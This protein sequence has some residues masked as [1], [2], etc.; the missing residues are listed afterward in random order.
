M[1]C[2]YYKRSNIT[3]IFCMRDLAG[4][5]IP[6]IRFLSYSDLPSIYSS[7]AREMQ[8]GYHLKIRIFIG[9][10]TELIN[11]PGSNSHDLVSLTILTEH[12]SC[13]NIEQIF[14]LLFFKNRQKKIV[15]NT[16]ISVFPIS[17]RSM[18]WILSKYMNV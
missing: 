12:N 4:N 15:I 1:F 3:L 8:G 2:L 10:F 9:A 17:T 7:Y 6:T 13:K 11:S 16:G 18:C 14:S 5:F